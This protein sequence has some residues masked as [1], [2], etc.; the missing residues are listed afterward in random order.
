MAYFVAEMFEPDNAILFGSRPHRF[1]SE[2]VKMPLGQVRPPYSASHSLS[3]LPPSQA[4][5]ELRE[6][7]DSRK[8][9]PLFRITADA[10]FE[11]DHKFYKH[12][13]CGILYPLR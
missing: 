5:R 2:P 7:A 3:H 10:S 13:P 11:I 1:T 8:H 6:C 4:A 9:R 12:F